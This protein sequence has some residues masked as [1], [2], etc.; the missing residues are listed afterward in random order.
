M[1]KKIITGNRLRTMYKRQKSPPWDRTY[2][3]SIFATPEEAPDI[4]RASILTPEMLGRLFH[5]LSE[6][7]KYFAILGFYSQ[8]FAGA[9]EQRMMPAFPIPNP[10]STMA[11]VTDTRTTNSSIDS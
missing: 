10:L 9:Q 8:K 5:C 6:P 4:S 7:E 1:T 3:A 11:G 2:L